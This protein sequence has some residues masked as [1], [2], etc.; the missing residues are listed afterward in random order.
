[1]ALVG[2]RSGDTGA[3]MTADAPPTVA[4]QVAALVRLFSL[5]GRV[6]LVTGATGDIGRE[7]ALTLSAAGAAVAL[8]GRAEERL[9]G[10]QAELA[11]MDRQVDTF[12][13]DLADIAACQAVVTRVVTT[14]GHLDIL[15]NCAGVNV[16]EPILDVDPTTFDTIM[17]LNLRSAYFVSQAAARVM[18]Q[19]DAGGKIINVGS[20]TSAI[21]LAE[22]S[23]YGASKA[24]LAQLT[25]TMAV[26]WARHNIQVNCLAPG[27]MLTSLTREALWGNEQK[28]RW[29]LDRIPARRPGLPTDLAG[30]ALLL[31]APASDY[32]TG[33]MLAV[34]GGLL[35]G[36]PW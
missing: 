17:A 35:A 14:F 11:G 30:A 32:L 7:I 23:V 3:A 27:F 16:R 15:V 13:A 12:A 36:S 34:D 5:A 31:A 24:A 8:T 25:K 21:G 26:E 20:L 10:L 1:M 2:R 18:I 9:R 33:Q 19:Q 29:M 28:R 22:V 4:P 6:A